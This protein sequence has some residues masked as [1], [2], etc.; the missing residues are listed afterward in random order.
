MRQK[1]PQVC[2]VGYTNAGKSTLMNALARSQ[3]KVEDQ[4]FSTLDTT[5]RRFYLPKAGTV[6]LSDTVGFIRKLPTHLVESFRS[7]LDVARDADLLLHVVD[8]TSTEQESHRKTVA[9]T[10]EQL[11]AG[12]VSRILVFNKIDLL[13]SP[14]RMLPLARHFPDAYFVSAKRGDGLDALRNAVDDALSKTARSLEPAGP[15]GR[16]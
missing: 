1:L 12:A 2:L 10:L 9:E 3:V 14:D 7:T 8:S 13:A 4:L 11:K 16:A 15:D 5:T 6:L